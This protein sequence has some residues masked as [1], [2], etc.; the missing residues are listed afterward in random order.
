MLRFLDRQL[1]AAEVS[2]LADRLRGDEGARRQAAGLLLQIGVLGELAREPRRERL[3]WRPRRKREPQGSRR[4]MATIAVCAGLAAAALVLLI[5]RLHPPARRAAAPGREPAAFARPTGKGVAPVTHTAP[6]T[7][8][9]ALLLRGSDH[10]DDRMVERLADLG[11]EV[12]QAFDANV[13]S[14]DLS[15]KALIVISASTAG[16][17]L[18]ERIRGLGLRTAPV[19]I[20]T[21]ETASFDELGLT[22]PRGGAGPP[23]GPNGFGSAPGHMSIEIEA[24]GHVLAAGLGGRLRIASAPVALSW[25]APA[26]SAIRVAS[27]GGGRGRHLIVQFAYETGAPMV[28]LAAP[29]RRVGCFVSAEAADALTTDG[30]QLFDAGVRWAIGR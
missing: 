20:V 22:G 4:T 5:G 3:P 30:W 18:R 1:T 19:P 15:G 27:L 6:G 10:R 13:S 24:A 7:S 17:V 14:E 12:S 9:P 2:A 8:G 21:C 11:F 25:G 29:A 16:D 23:G 26:D 28:G